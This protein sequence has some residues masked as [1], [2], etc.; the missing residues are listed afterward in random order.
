MGG[1]I[2]LLGALAGGY[3]QAAETERKR[4]FEADSQQRQNALGL[5]K[6]LLDSP[7]VPPEYKPLLVQYGMDVIHTPWGKKVPDFH[8]Q[9][10][11]QTPQVNTPAQTQN[12]P[13]PSVQL[14]MPAPPPQNPAAMGTGQQPQGA[15]SM[16]QSATAANGGTPAYQQT[17]PIP[18]APAGVGGANPYAN[19]RSVAS[20]S[21]ALPE[22]SPPPIPLA[23][24][25][26]GP[27]GQVSPTMTRGGGP[28]LPGGQAPVTLAPQQIAPAGQF[29]MLSPQELEQQQTT[30]MM[31]RAAQISRETGVPIARVLNMQEKFGT[32]PWGGGTYN[33]DTGEIESAPTA[34]PIGAPVK[35]TDETG[36]YHFIQRYQDGTMRPIAEPEGMKVPT[37]TAEKPT[38]KTT[39]SVFNPETG[40]TTTSSTTQKV[41]PSKL[42]STR[43]STVA[44]GGVGTVGKPGG[45]V[46]E[47]AN[48]WANDGI[49]PPAK[50]MPYVQKY[51]AANNMKPGVLPSAQAKGRADAGVAIKPLIEDVR[52]MLQD[53]DVRSQMGVFSGR[54]T[55]IE[56]K[57][58]TIDPK[59]AKLYGEL[60]SIY[61]LA[62]AMHGWRAIKVAEEFE[63]A[64]GSLKTNPDALLAGM[65]SMSDTAQA[66]IDAGYNTISGK[67]KGGGVNPPPKPEGKGGFDWSAHPEVKQ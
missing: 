29:H 23:P 45:V 50:Y 66:V 20:Q 24:P 26:I 17:V 61:S 56:R 12:A 36:A 8:K 67:P 42:K 9:V 28:T 4:Q 65:D 27:N 14:G 3:A 62:G 34:K 47:M 7:N 52:T 25:T 64:Y 33:K 40:T 19:P 35:M 51:M 63:K 21:Q 10:V 32:V 5:T 30:L 22:V 44:S 43:I 39:T 53:P 37:P 6:I 11:T 13:I 55:D 60:K 49:K 57:L 1:G 16:T 31:N 59:M 38:V 15:P 2:G 58:G 18:A 48:E 54:T 41:E 46:S